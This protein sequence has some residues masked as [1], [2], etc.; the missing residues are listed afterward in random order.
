[1]YNQLIY[2]I[3]VLL[4]FS[5]QQ[6]TAG[7]TPPPWPDALYIAAFFGF[8]V[9]CCRRA[10]GRLKKAADE[11][12][13]P[14]VL[15]RAYFRAETLFSIAAIG[16]LAVYLYAL[17][18]GA[19]LSVIPGYSRLTTVSGIIGLAIYM[20]HLTV[21]YVFRHTVGEFFSLRS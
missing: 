21:V 7:P 5:T 8:F 10:F 4:L 3:V 17:N 9:F 16:F 14:S 19:Y 13:S 11:D 18:L 1:M 12:G 20:L 6:P 15:A 2:F